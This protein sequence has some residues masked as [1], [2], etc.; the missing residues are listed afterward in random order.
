MKYTINILQENKTAFIIELLSSFDFIQIEPQTNRVQ[1]WWNEL[2]EEDKA[3]L[4]ESLLQ[5]E[6]GQEKSMEE[7]FKK[8]KKQ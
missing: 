1:D 2:T 4:K 7:V 8:Y 6:A 3:D 5:G